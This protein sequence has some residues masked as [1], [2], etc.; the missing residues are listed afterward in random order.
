MSYFSVVHQRKYSLH[1]ITPRTENDENDALDQTLRPIKI[2]SSWTDAVYLQYEIM[3]RL[4]TGF[5]DGIYVI[6]VFLVSTL[7]LCSPQTKINQKP[8]GTN[9]YS[10]FI[11]FLSTPLQFFI[12]R[13]R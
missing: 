7:V 6:L 12:R 4:V 10:P 13:Q 5:Y 1:K 11:Q 9:V 2:G 8:K 3:S